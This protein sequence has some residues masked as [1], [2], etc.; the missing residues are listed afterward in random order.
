MFVKQALAGITMLVAGLIVG[1]I[2]SLVTTSHYFPSGPGEIDR[3]WHHSYF[4]RHTYDNGHTVLEKI[5]PY[6]FTGR[7]QESVPDGAY[8]IQDGQVIECWNNS[9]KTQ[10]KLSG[11]VAIYQNIALLEPCVIGSGIKGGTLL[12]TL[13]DKERPGGELRSL[14]GSGSYLVQIY[15]G[16]DE[17]TKN[18]R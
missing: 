11:T 14:V 10:N 9:L 5:D 17:R 3:R 2:L 16:V 8:A 6:E 15:L 13:I 7:N 1:G 18:D 12:G 4:A